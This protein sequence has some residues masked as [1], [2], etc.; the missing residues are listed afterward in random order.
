MGVK[1]T[2]PCPTPAPAP[3]LAGFNRLVEQ[4]QTV[5]YTVA[6]RLLGEAGA[7]TTATTT[8]LTRAYQQPGPAHCPA[9]L[10]LLRCL[11]AACGSAPS[12]SAGL[13]ALPV[14]QR[15]VV[16]LVDIAGLDYAQAGVVLDW[17]PPQVRA[18]L[19][20]ARRA[21]MLQRAEAAVVH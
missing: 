17:P 2:A 3:D 16:A 1:V 12:A 18:R 15:Q 19:A 9:L 4:H 6:Y 11:L 10:C 14:Q 7:A 13:A 20:A 5:L 21:L 8:A